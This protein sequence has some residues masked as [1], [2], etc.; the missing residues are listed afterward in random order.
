MRAVGSGK[1]KRGE[2]WREART[3]SPS[4]LPSASLP[5]LAHVQPLGGGLHLR[6]AGL[7]HWVEGGVE[8]NVA[9]KA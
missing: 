4:P 6:Q 2:R 8:G 7:R 3:V 1:V 9:K 5:H